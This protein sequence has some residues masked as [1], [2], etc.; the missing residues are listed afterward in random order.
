MNGPRTRRDFLRLAAGAATVA[1]TGAACNSGSDKPKASTA[2]KAGAEGDRI[3]RIAMWSHFIPSYDAWFDEEYTRRWGEKHDLE[4][5][6]DHIPYAELGARAGAEVAAE[7]G[8][9]IFAFITPPPIFEDEV[10]DHREIVEEVEAKLGKLAPVVERNVLNP[11]TGKYFG[12]GEYWAPNPVHYRVDLWDRAEPGL[13]PGTWDD[14]LRAAPKLKAMGYPVGI[15]MSPDDDSNFSLSSLLAAYGSR[16][17]DEEGGVAINSPA[18]VE[19]VKMGTAIYRAGMTDEVFFWESSSNNRL[20]ATGRGSLILNAISAVRDAEDQD[21]DLAGKIALAPA[22]AGPV[23]RLGAHSVVNIHV[24]WRF[25]KNQEAAK[26][27]LVDLALDYREAFLRSRFYNLP[28]FPRAVP[29]LTELVAK[30]DKAQPSGKYALLADAEKWSTNIGHPSHANAATDEVFNQSVIPKMFAAA[31]RGEMS[32][33]EAVRT[34]EARMKPIFEK[35][36]EK[37]KI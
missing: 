26:Q 28:A 22:P 3:L 9:D 13:K 7:R 16:I 20:L 2:A 5:V 12:F 18:T 31:A 19:A 33:E 27:F 23:A 34:A 30:D 36:R 4:V 29:D 24:I 37:G 1:A 32:A 21:R 15:G 17:Q 35:W 11:K 10:I 14:V 8:H 6:V 25:S